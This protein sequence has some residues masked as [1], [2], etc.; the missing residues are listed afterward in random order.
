MLVIRDLSLPLADFSLDLSLEIRAHTTALFG[1]S[2]A[3]KTSLL[4]VIAGMRRPVRGLVE[5]HGRTVFDA[6]HG[7]DVPSR[8]RRVGYVPQDD[9]LFPHL[10]VR[11]NVFYGADS[12]DEQAPALELLELLPLMQRSISSLSGGERKRVALARALFSAPRI[13]LLDEPLSGVDSALK[14]RIL[15][16]L[17]RLRD[18]LAVPLV[19]VT[20]H[21]DEIADLCEQSIELA[22]GRVLG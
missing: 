17:A 19:F 20:H 7:I 5:L 8:E 2:G 13:L 16:Y 9:V 4:E 14:T 3:G 11:R 21:R 12:Q 6:A 10:D 18:E 1:P 15:G 22:R